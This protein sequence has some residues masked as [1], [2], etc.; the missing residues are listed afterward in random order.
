[1]NNPNYAKHL[2]KALYHLD[3]AG[4]YATGRK[5]AG[6]LFPYRIALSRM[7]TATGYEFSN[8]PPGIRRAK[9]GK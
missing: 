3:H 7:L 2:A 1:M 5:E 9:G 8:R 6:K 4:V